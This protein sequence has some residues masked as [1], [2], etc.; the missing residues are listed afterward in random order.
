MAVAVSSMRKGETLID[1]AVTLNAM[2][3]DVL[4]VRHFRVGRGA[5]VVGKGRLLRH[6]RRRRF[7][8]G[9]QLTQAL[10]DALDDPPPKGKLGGLTVAICG[11]VLHFA[12]SA[13]DILLLE[14]DGRD[15]CRWRQCTLLPASGSSDL[16]PRH[17]RKGLKDVD[18]VMDAAA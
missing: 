4:A 15:G 9:E 7:S 5:A 1:T 18:I 11:D 2:H 14:R 3:P 10:L 13:S 8:H 12:A 16:A 6:Q 17:G